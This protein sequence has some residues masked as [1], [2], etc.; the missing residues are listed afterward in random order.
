MRYENWA[1]RLAE[2][3][4]QMHALQFEQGQHDCGHF[5]AG[6]VQAITGVDHISAYHGHYTTVQGYLRLLKR[7]GHDSVAAYVSSVLGEPIPVLAAQRGDVVMML[8]GELEA[9]GIC[10]GTRAIFLNHDGGLAEL[11]VERCQM[12]WRVA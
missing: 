12:A 7:D 8:E 3:L 6:A 4:S 1:E 9:L 2:Y 11:P 10:D 5:V